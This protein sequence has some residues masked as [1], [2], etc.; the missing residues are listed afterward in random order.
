MDYA[1]FCVLPDGKPTFA[2]AIP[3]TQ[4]VAK[5]KDAIKSKIPLSLNAI[6]ARDLTLY[7]I[8]LD[9]SDTKYIEEVK[10]LVRKLDD[11]HQLNQL[12]LLDMVFPE[13]PNPR[14]QKIH[15]L[16]VPPPGETINSGACG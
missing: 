2:V 9:G 4:T 14:D 8:D 10:N 7:E 13:P 16:V 5:L 12:D 15:I 3:K 1:L 6:E 11:L